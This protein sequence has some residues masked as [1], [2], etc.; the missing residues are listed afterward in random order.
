[1]IKKD[2]IDQVLRL[3]MRIQ[4]SMRDD[5]PD[6]WLA[7]NLSIAQ[8]KSLFFINFQGVTNAK[9]LASALGV[10][11]PNV[12]G[13]IDRLVEHNMVSREYNQSNRRMQMLKLT[14]TGVKLVTELKESTTSRYS[15]LLEQLEVTDLAVLV[16]GLSA[17][18]KAAEHIQ[19]TGTSG[20]VKK[21]L[22]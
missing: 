17:L 7:L 20:R 3:Q 5:A 2:L 10:T 6:A 15:R 8:L 12:T 18:A 14:P 22:S 21:G 16:Q 19:K 4:R 13:I 11:P 1:M 9:S